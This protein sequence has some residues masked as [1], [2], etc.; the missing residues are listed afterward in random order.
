MQA[1]GPSL[2]Q[3]S[4]CLQKICRHFITRLPYKRTDFMSSRSSAN[5]RR[6]R[7][8]SI[9]L[10][11]SILTVAFSAQAADALPNTL[12][13]ENAQPILST[14]AT[15]VQVYSCEYDKDHHLAWTFQH[16]E[17][18]LYDDNGI[19][20]IRHGAGPSWKR[21]DD[22][23]TIKGKLIAQAPSSNAGSIP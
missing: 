23:S 7:A 4:T 17:A 22:G 21:N 12:A 9:A 1:H 19:A 16:P 2:I 5:N 14:T 3:V 15:G 13:P 6:T 20:V 8:I 18:T 10:G 11:L